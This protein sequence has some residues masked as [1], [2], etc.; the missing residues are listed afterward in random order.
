MLYAVGDIHG[1]YELLSELLANLPLREGDSLVFMG[2]YVDRGPDSREV[3]DVLLEFQKA[4][5]CVFLMGNHESMFLNFL[6]WRGEEYFGGDAF[7]MN[8]GDRTLASYGYFDA[9]DPDVKSF[10]LPKEHERFYRDLKLY[11][12]DGDY[13]FVHAGIG[14]DLLDESDV[15]YAVRNARCEDLLWDRSTIDL[16]HK[17]GVTVIYGHTPSM[18]FS[19]RWN[20]PF[21]IGIDTG[22][23]YGGNL[24]A[25]RLPDETL[26]QV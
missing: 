7:L 22:A 17:L 15:D 12:R 13:L 9:D 8:G 6:G 24:T 5:P 25:I 3:V 26:F 4:W 19:V 1:E 18:D 10:S 2:D 16:P 11:H 14:R 20:T 21:S 23:V